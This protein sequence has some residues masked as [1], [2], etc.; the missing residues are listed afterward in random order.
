MNNKIK[1]IGNVAIYHV[2]RLCGGH[3]EGGWYYQE[4]VRQG[5]VHRYDISSEEKY[6]KVQDFMTRVQRMLDH[7][8]PMNQR[9]LSSVLSAGQMRVELWENEEAPEVYPKNTPH[10]E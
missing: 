9:P 2:Q 1:K 10:Y 8:Y 5:K 3:E 4:G 6:E 7:A